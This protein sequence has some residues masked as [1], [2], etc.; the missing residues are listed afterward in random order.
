M[1][2]D[3][4]S[5]SQ[6]RNWEEL[7]DG[8]VI[9]RHEIILDIFAE[10]ATSRES[11]LQV[12]LAR[13]EY[14]L[15]RL[16]RAWTHLSRQRG[17]RQGTRG[18][19]EMQLEVDRRIVLRK[20]ARFKR[21]LTELARQRALR[22]S[23]RE[24]IPVPDAAIVGYTNAGKSSLLNALTGANVEVAD[25]LFKTLDATTRRLAIPNGLDLLLTDTVGFIRKL[26]HDLVDAFKSTLE[27]ARLAD[28]LIIVLDVSDP[29][30]AH[31][32]QTTLSVLRDIGAETDSSIIVLN[33]C[34]LV[35][36]SESG[37]AR[38]RYPEAI[39]TSSKRG[40]GLDELKSRLRARLHSSM[41]ITRFVLPEARH[42]LAAMIH[43]SGRIVEEVYEN[44]SI[45]LTAQV[46]ELTQGRLRKYVT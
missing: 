45:I 14:S 33:K 1:F 32:Y 13:A 27:E 19:G 4:L 18:E 15:P 6:Q 17:G 26:P 11:V 43:R 28:F 36:E 24:S 8:C 38:Q 7:T 22:R 2:D 9:D 42:D 37:D 20:I 44:G 23:R 40:I 3:D 29:A 39:L 21:E 5:P 31:H 35:G 12:A 16:T 30:C 34:D 41:A 46:S 10:H 25:E